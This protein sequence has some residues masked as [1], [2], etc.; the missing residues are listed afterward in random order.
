MKAPKIPP[1]NLTSYG[2]IVSDYKCISYWL[3]GSVGSGV[4]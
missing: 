4:I 3:E 1:K 2:K